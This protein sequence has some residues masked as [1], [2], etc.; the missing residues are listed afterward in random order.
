M[1]NDRRFLN[2]FGIV[3]VAILAWLTGYTISHPSRTQ[4][5]EQVLQQQDSKMNQL[6][7]DLADYIA[8]KLKEEK[9]NS[10][11]LSLDVATPTREENGT[12]KFPYVISFS[13][14]VE[15]EATTSYVFAH[16]VLQPEADRWKII[17]VNTERETV[18][19]DGGALIAGS[20]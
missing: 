8:D 5:Q 7:S 1:K 17:H 18:N 6:R 4:L 16:A 14:L 3:I 10:T 11:I 2:V 13:D 15:G 12:L 9:Q 20:K 19:Y